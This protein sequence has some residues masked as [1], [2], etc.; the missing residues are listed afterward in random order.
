MP[1]EVSRL[2]NVK[3]ADTQHNCITYL[4]HFLGSSV[5][6]DCDFLPCFC[7][8]YVTVVLENPDIVTENVL[9]FRD[10]YTIKVIFLYRTH[11]NRKPTSHQN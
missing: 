7:A 4:A 8:K 5:S 11:L 3:K 2:L 9:I 10:I 1:Y 6:D